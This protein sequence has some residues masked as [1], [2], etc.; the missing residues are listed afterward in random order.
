[1]I[2]SGQFEAIVFGRSFGLQYWWRQWLR[3]VQIFGGFGGI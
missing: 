2:G 1:M 3:L